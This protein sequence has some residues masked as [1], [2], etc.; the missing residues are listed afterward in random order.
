[1]SSSGTSIFGNFSSTQPTTNYK[2]S[3]KSPKGTII[4]NPL[5]KNAQFSYG[6]S[7]LSTQQPS[8]TLQTMPRSPLMAMTPNRDNLQ[9]QQQ[10][11]TKKMN[12]IATPGPP[13]K[14]S[15]SLMGGMAMPMQ[16]SLG[17]KT[18]QVRAHWVRSCRKIA[19]QS[20]ASTAKRVVRMG[21]RESQSTVYYPQ[22]VSIVSNISTSPSHTK[23]LHRINCLIS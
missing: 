4:E 1:M 8:S 9:H 14:M 17:R 12:Q 23:N 2:K 15:L 11:K 22:W 20:N 3:P 5:M 19:I 10:H 21:E 6:G 13:P 7:A 18:S 16:V